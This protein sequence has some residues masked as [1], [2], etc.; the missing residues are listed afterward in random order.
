MVHPTV[1]HIHMEIFLALLSSRLRSLTVVPKSYMKTVVIIMSVATGCWETNKPRLSK[2]ALFTNFPFVSLV[3][4]IDLIIIFYFFSEIPASMSNSPTGDGSSDEDELWKQ[5]GNPEERDEPI[6]ETKDE[7][8]PLDT[9]ESDATKATSDIGDIERKREEDARQ[10][11]LYKE[12][13]EGFEAEK[14][15]EKE[16]E[17]QKV[18]ERTAQE[19]QREA[20]ELV[21]LE[22]ER[23]ERKREKLEAEERDRA[24]QALQQGVLEME[25]M[26]SES[27]NWDED[28]DAEE[29][30]EEVSEEKT[31]VEPVDVEPAEPIEA[32]PDDDGEVHSDDDEPKEADPV[33]S[34]L[35]AE[36]ER[37]LQAIQ[38]E[39]GLDDE[40][41]ED[42]EVSSESE[43]EQ[44]VD[45][46]PVDKEETEVIED[47][48]EV[49]LRLEQERIQQ[50]IEARINVP[51]P[52]ADKQATPT[53]D[54]KQDDVVSER[55]EPMETDETP[56]PQEKLNSITQEIVET[57]RS[58]YTGE[59]KGQ[60]EEATTAIVEELL[61]EELDEPLVEG[62]E[63]KTAQKRSALEE[64]A[65]PPMKIERKEEIKRPR[66]P[67]EVLE[68]VRLADRGVTD[69]K[70]NL[71]KVRTFRYC[72]YAGFLKL[73]L[74]YSCNPFCI[75]PRGIFKRKLRLGPLPGLRFVLFT[76]NTGKIPGNL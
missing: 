1:V 22:I 23:W 58:G 45:D 31:P 40:A 9:S 38:E 71:Q 2:S 33:E 32:D 37:L 68:L 70:K 57:L 12:A 49:A 74:F 46:V 59:M 29:V 66:H 72:Q 56:S 42:G 26:A 15:L 36:R 43:E 4:P 34:S 25:A 14:M 69:M 54:H 7:T 41:V 52:N 62:S 64:S 3:Q 50:E 5:I 21:K 63:E 16:K 8:S 30:V 28:D 18:A 6:E 75:R 76:R 47:P 65:A 13:F 53:D 35:Q 67:P 61:K 10:L 39:E 60:T 48:V 44:K 27:A 73:K 51:T 11:R 19:Q 24:E 20:E 17:M 55:Q